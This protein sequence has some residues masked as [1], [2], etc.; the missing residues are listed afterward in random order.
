MWDHYEVGP[1]TLD[2]WTCSYCNGVNSGTD[3][4]CSACKLPRW[5]VTC[6]ACKKRR[7]AGTLCDCASDAS[8][9][10]PREEPQASMAA[11]PDDKSRWWLCQKCNIRVFGTAE[12]V[13]NAPGPENKWND[14]HKERW[15][16]CTKCNACIKRGVACAGCGATGKI[17]R[18]EP[19]ASTS[20]GTPLVSCT[21]KWG[22]PGCNVTNE[23]TRKR[24]FSCGRE[25][26][27]N[28][29]EPY[30]V[31]PEMESL[32]PQTVPPYIEWGCLVCGQK[33]G[34]WFKRC[35]RIGCNMG[36]NVWQCSAGS[37]GAPN[38]IRRTTCGKCQRPRVQPSGIVIGTSSTI[39][40]GTSSTIIPSTS[41]EPNAGLEWHDIH[42]RLQRL[43]TSFGVSLPVFPPV[44]PAQ[45]SQ[46]VTGW[47]CGVCRVYVASGDV[48][49][50]CD[51][52]RDA[53]WR[54]DECQLFNYGG[55]E[56]E[57]CGIPRLDSPASTSSSQGKIAEQ[58][59]PGEPV[60]EA[61]RCKGCL[62]VRAD[63]T[64]ATCDRC[65]T[66]TIPTAPVVAQEPADVVMS[67]TTPSSGWTCANCS[68]AQPEANK[69][70]GGCGGTRAGEGG[71]EPCVICMEKPRDALLKHPDGTG[72]MCV[73]MTCSYELGKDGLCPMCRMPIVEVIRV[74]G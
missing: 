17:P 10:T 19:Q 8:G 5:S 43:Q 23:M 32:Y 74:F 33:N 60:P 14:M 16:M 52:P 58:L 39:I 7:M 68:A 4:V 55:M 41:S 62:H 71:A 69:F 28:E 34:P 54:C 22:C 57:R 25:Y 6:Q 2:D 11:V 46:T 36:R 66:P 27:I 63:M 61:R 56:C 21:A 3:M 26:R 67:D 30:D 18:E 50:V 49:Q 53:A 42:Q 70:C 24:C 20:G 51:A 1:P 47:T 73:C 64:S 12:C 13:C 59:P 65:G 48:C 31:E 37:C 9:K 35:M 44:S 29:R 45:T 38:T 72:H 15:W 40:P